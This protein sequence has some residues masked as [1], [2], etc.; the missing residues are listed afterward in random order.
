MEDDLSF[1]ENGRRPQFFF[2]WK[3][4]SILLKME[5]DLNSFENGRRPQFIDNRRRL[6]F[7]VNGRRPYFFVN[8]R[9]LISYVNGNRRRLIFWVNEK[10]PKEST[11]RGVPPIF[12]YPKSYFLVTIN[13]MQNFRTLQ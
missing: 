3:T 5:D 4:T 11:P 1:L 10:K 12:V 8:G 2:K 6:T 13:P 7:F 9:Q